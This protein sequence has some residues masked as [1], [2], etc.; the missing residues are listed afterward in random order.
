MYSFKCYKGDYY[1]YATGV[2]MGNP[3]EYV[4]GGIPVKV[5]RNEEVRADVAVTEHH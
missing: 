4:N 1:L 3:P 2:E 5:K